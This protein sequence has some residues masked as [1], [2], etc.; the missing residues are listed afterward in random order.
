MDRAWSQIATPTP[1]RL[2]GQ[3]AP[4]QPSLLLAQK[5]SYKLGAAAQR[6]SP[7]QPLIDAEPTNLPRIPSASDQQMGRLRVALSAA[8]TAVTLD[9]HNLP[10]VQRPGIVSSP[11]VN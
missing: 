8:K 2:F 5:R 4:D 1:A 9:S 10:S 7:V 6:D 3:Q 11:P